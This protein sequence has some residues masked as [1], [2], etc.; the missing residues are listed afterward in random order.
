VSGVVNLFEA[1]RALEEN[2]PPGYEVPFV[3]LGPLVGGSA[4]GLT[5][6]ELPE[7]TAS[8]PTTTST[9]ARSG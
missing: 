4:L 3:R 5:V 1:P 7:G 2:D 8:V 6:Y 9:R